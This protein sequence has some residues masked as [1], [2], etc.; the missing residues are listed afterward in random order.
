MRH[1]ILGDKRTGLAKKSLLVE[2]PRIPESQTVAHLDAN[3]KNGNVI[4]TGMIGND[5]I[6]LNS[7]NP[8]Q[9][10]RVH[11]PA[12]PAQVVVAFRDVDAQGKKHDDQDDDTEE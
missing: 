11:L 6:S 12:T 5:P 10:H 2:D 9:R 1:S 3:P 4:V 8:V 7:A